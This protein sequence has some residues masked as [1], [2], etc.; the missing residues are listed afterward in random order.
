MS[1]EANMFHEGGFTIINVSLF[2]AELTSLR[3]SVVGVALRCLSQT[4]VLVRLWN[5]VS[6]SASFPSCRSK[7]LPKPG[8][9]FQTEISVPLW[10]VWV[11]PPVSPFIDMTSFDSSGLVPFSCLTNS[12]FL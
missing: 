4:S 11:W 9:T 5:L 1:H 12:D 7:D 2:L 8:P 10:C 3:P 6:R